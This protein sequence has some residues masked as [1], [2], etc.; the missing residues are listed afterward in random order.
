MDNL[1]E[2][3]EDIKDGFKTGLEDPVSLVT[4]IEFYLE[5][6]TENGT[7]EERKKFLE[8]LD[9]QL[10]ANKDV[11]FKVSWD[12]PKQFI[13]LISGKNIKIYE[14]LRHNIILPEIMKCFMSLTTHGDPRELLIA[15]CE[16][17]ESLSAKD[18]T[19]DYMAVTKNDPKVELTN[20]NKMYMERSL[21]DFFLGLK[22]HMVY[23]MIFNSLKRIDTLYPSKYLNIAVSA[24]SKLI[25]TNAALMDDPSIILRRAYLFCKTYIPNDPPEKVVLKDG[26]KLE[27]EALEEIIEKEV[28]VQGNL[29][30]HLCTVAA[31]DGLNGSSDRSE[32]NYYYTISHKELP[33]AP[34]YE[35]L[36]DTKL[37]L[38]DLAISF[39]ID[40]KEELVNCV[41]DSKRIY[42]ALPKLE[43]VP[44]KEARRLINKGVIRLSLSYQL[45]KMARDTNVTLYPQGIIVLSS[46][47][48]LVTKKHLYP[49]IPLSDTV[50]LYL[51]FVS[52]GIMSQ[53][54]S[55]DAV[56]GAIRYFIWVHVTTNSCV[57]LREELS[58]LSPFILEP[59]FECFLIRISTTTHEENKTIQYTLFTRLLCCAPESVSFQFICNVLQEFPYIEGKYLV[60][61]IL[62]HLFTNKFP[63]ESNTKELSVIVEDQDDKK[64]VDDELTSKL[65]GLKIGDSK[66][67]GKNNDNETI[68]NLTLERMSIMTD[69]I[70]D[71][72]KE[73]ISVGET[74][75]KFKLMILY[76]DF[77]ITMKKTWNMKLLK[78]VERTTTPLSS[79][80]HVQTL[81]KHLM[82]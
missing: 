82:A 19:L 33:P 63:K 7:C 36:L 17:L 22:L 73:S 57:K 27:G 24:F 25:R 53:M 30:R 61:G 37:R 60:I 16:I 69:I 43:D 70:K 28:E 14:V 80:E 11:T 21:G 67:D 23:E 9:E 55:N 48:N 6:L 45:Q 8:M 20:E 65:S 72:I 3:E 12:L 18:E 81:I 78:S 26:E 68:I 64:E 76:L 15:G 5:E 49:Q 74:D 47:Y 77:L 58:S 29:L 46:I 51:R 2:I 66:N 40:L 1:E 41:K 34:F 31:S 62:K 54:Y 50:V 13:N 56:D 39:D 32:F 44:N 79:N 35:Q 52:L 59:F 38:Y 10:E 42:K 71:A 4:L 75:G